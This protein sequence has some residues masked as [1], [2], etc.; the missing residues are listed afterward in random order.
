MFGNIQENSKAKK[1]S[2]KRKT[3]NEMNKN[4]EELG[5]RT[6]KKKKKKEPHIIH[7]KRQTDK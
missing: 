4:L 2:T 3:K 7:R 6:W 5:R 1:N